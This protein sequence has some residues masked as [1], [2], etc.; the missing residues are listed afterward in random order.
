MNKPHWTKAEVESLVFMYRA[1]TPV[2]E[3]SQS[4]Q[5]SKASV[6]NYVYRNRDKLGLG[7][8]KQP[9]VTLETAIMPTKRNQSFWERMIDGVIGAIKK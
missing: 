1:G 4:L 2:A 3:I 6:Q 7:R 5:R 9:P 8:R